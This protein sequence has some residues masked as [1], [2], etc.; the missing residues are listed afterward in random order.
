[1]KIIPVAEVLGYIKKYQ[2][3]H[4]I[5]PKIEYY[6]RNIVDEASMLFA[7]DIFDLSKLRI[8]LL[9]GE[10]SLTENGKLILKE[11]LKIIYTDG[12]EFKVASSNLKTI[13]IPPIQ[14]LKP[15]IDGAVRKA[16]EAAAI[17]RTLG[18]D[19]GL[20]ITLTGNT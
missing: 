10:Y 6:T 15:K 20:E 2:N 16:A 14:K 13:R 12:I 17:S 8:G 1:M 7:H 5:Y 11:R 9:E 4:E 3:N 18:N 19:I